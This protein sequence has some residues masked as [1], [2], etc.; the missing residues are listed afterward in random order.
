MY[1]MALVLIRITKTELV[2]ATNTATT[3]IFLINTSASN[4]DSAVFVVFERARPMLILLCCRRSV[5]TLVVTRIRRKDKH[6]TSL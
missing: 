6:E 4:L 2:L 5:S 3:S 1:D